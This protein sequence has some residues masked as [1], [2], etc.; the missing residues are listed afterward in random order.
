MIYVKQGLGHVLTKRDRVHFLIRT[1][2]YKV[3]FIEKLLW[4]MFVP[5]FVDGEYWEFVLMQK[6]LTPLVLERLT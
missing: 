2:C 6:C 1:L 5:L 3:N 4:K